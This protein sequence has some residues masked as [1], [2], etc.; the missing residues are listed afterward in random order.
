MNVVMWKC[1]MDDSAKVIYGMILGR[2]LWT[3]LV[4]NRKFS[5]HVIEA[6]DGPFIVATAH[7]V[8]LGTYVFKYLNTGE[9]KPEE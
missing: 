4:L 5:Y 1:H 2:Y 3:E 8:D 9:V 7:M 6:Y